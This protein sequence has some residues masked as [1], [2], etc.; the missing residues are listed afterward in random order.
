MIVVQAA[1]LKHSIPKL[2]DPLRLQR[3]K[4][5]SIPATL[6]LLASGGLLFPNIFV[7][8]FRFRFNELGHEVFALC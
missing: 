1:A 7:P 3:L 5:S 6:S 8:N 4:K 2:R